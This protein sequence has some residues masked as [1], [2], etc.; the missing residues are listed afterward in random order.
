MTDW[1]GAEYSALSDLQRAMAADAIAGLA[2]AGTN[3]VLDIG[4]GDGFLTSA[5]ADL[6]PD[7][8]ASIVVGMDPSPGMIASARSMPVTGRSGP[9][10]V[11]ADARQLPFAEQFD[12]VVSFNALHWVP[13]QQHALAQIAAV[14]RPEGRALIQVVC[15]GQ[16]P[17][18]EMVAMELTRS[19]RWASRFAGFRPPFVHVDAAHYE[20]LVTA[21]G[22]ALERLLVTEQ[23]W[24]FGSRG[25]FESWCAVGTTAWTDRLDPDEGKRFVSDLVRAYESVS[26]EPGLFLFTQMRAELRRLVPSED[27]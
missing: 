7:G 6:V 18:V 2:L 16:R 15:A 8:P 23:H 12:V 5:I 22:L 17:S 10:F 27:H 4:C 24:D 13:E 14:L 20:E 1:N 3:R 19:N 25:Q 9:H 21:A 26:G 11:R